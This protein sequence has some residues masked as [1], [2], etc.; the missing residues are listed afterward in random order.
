MELYDEQYFLTLGLPADNNTHTEIEQISL[1]MGEMYVIS[2]H[3]GA[4]DPFEAVRKRLRNRKNRIRNRGA[5]YLLYALL[6]RVVDQG[7]PVLE[8]FG[9]KIEKLEMELLD[10]PDQETLNHIHQTKRNLLLLR[11]MIWP[12]RELI[13]LLLR[14]ESPLI[15]E[16]TKLYLRDCYD[17][18]VQILDLLE[19]YRDMTASM[20]DV[21]L[22][23]T[24]H[25]LNEVMKVL[26]IIATIFIPLTFIAG[27]YGMN[28]GRKEP[29]SP[30]AMPELDWYY[31]YPL[32]WLIMIAMVM[33]MVG[34]FKYKRW[35]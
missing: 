22:S 31:G 32:I 8:R 20:L 29:I 23:S 11:R 2:F 18:S 9:E 17:H 1:F 6:D 25:R 33:V 15:K 26:T 12:Q 30:W 4:V 7:F 24:S 5:D 19:T 34:Y 3:A 13:N 16:D 27:V 10:R 21:Y 35:F 28:F 14:E